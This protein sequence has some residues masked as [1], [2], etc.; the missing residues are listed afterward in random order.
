MLVHITCS[1]NQPCVF[2]VAVNA[3]RRMM[4]GCLCV[5]DF[6]LQ[7]QRG[8]FDLVWSEIPVLDLVGTP[9]FFLGTEKVLMRC[10]PNQPLLNRRST[11]YIT[12]SVNP[13]VLTIITDITIITIIT[14]LL[15]VDIYLYPP[16]DIYI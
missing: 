1:P 13:T 10:S 6:W 5:E 9:V 16:L 3:N 7:I 12:V 8:P 11:Y 14:V 2:S 4:K 15:I